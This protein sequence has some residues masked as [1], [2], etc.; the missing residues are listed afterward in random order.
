MSLSGGDTHGVEEVM[1]LAVIDSQKDEALALLGNEIFDLVVVV[2][3][4]QTTQDE[5]GW[6]CH[7]LQCVPAGIDI[8]GFGVVD[9]GDTMHLA[10]E[11]Q[12]VLHTLEI[13]EALADDIVRDAAEVGG[14]TCC[15]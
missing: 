2:T 15:Q 14:D 6:L 11:L 12:T 9:E 5:D 1:Q 8:R 4:V 10:G 13:A 3:L 7:A